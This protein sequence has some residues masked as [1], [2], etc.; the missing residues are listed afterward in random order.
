V[1]VT[2]P[3]RFF[4][5]RAERYRYQARK[6]EAAASCMTSEV[7]RTGWL[8]IARDWD[9]LAMDVEESPEPDASVE[10]RS[11]AAGQNAEAAGTSGLQG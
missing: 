5:A 11:P 9:A 3:G 10:A 8:K 4:S 2:F 7:L 1:T 6:A